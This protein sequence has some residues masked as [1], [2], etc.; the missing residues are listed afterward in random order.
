M[1]NV[2]VYYELLKRTSEDSEIRI[3][4]FLMLMKCSD[5]SQK[6]QNF[7]KND[8]GKFLVNEKDLQVD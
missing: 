6:F 8:L 7:A 3:N 1:E 2:D 5:D 4:S